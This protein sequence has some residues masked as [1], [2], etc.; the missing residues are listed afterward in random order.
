VDP[1]LSFDLLYRFWRRGPAVLV[2]CI[3]SSCVHNHLKALDIGQA[4]TASIDVWP[5]SQH[6]NHERMICVIFF[7]GIICSCKFQ[8][9]VPYIWNVLNILNMNYLLVPAQLQL[10]N[11]KWLIHVA[12]NRL[13][14]SG[15][16]LGCC[17]SFCVYH[18][19]LSLKN[20]KSVKF[21]FLL[22][23]LYVIL[24]LIKS[25]C[26]IHIFVCKISH[27]KTFLKDFFSLNFFFNSKQFTKFQG[28]IEIVIVN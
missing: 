11:G 20:S 6:M 25:V 26:N 17:D 7:Y 15:F 18:S 12:Q 9:K 24:I 16:L 14:F 23:I 10:F 22:L 21:H 13:H 4:L 28:S 19:L 8:T 3:P 1:R 2:R 27:N 5:V